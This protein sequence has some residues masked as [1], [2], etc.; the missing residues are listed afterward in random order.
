MAFANV[1]ILRHGDL[2]TAAEWAEALRAAGADKAAAAAIE[3]TTELAHAVADATL[4]VE[5][6]VEDLATKRN[7]LAAV[8]EVAPADA[9]LASTT[10]ALSIDDIAAAVRGPERVVVLHFFYP[11][12]LIPLVEVVPATATLP[13]TVAITRTMLERIGKRPVVLA[14]Q[15]PGFVGNRLLHALIRQAIA[16]VRTGVVAAEDVDTALAMIDARLSDIA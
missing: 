2:P 12:L 6:V 10:S 9:I 5:A 15:I 13:A 11:P 1:A 16:L 8:A 14:R 4:V 3:T 7:L